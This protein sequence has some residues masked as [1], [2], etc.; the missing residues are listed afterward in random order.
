MWYRWKEKRALALLLLVCLALCLLIAALRGLL[1]VTQG[2]PAKESE[3]LLVYLHEEDRVVSMDLDTYLYGVVGGEMPASFPLEALKAQAVAARTYAVRRMAAYGG[4]PCGRGGADVCTDSTCCQSYKSPETLAER[5]GADAARNADKLKEAVAETHGIIAVYNGEPIEALYHSTT[6]G[7]TEDAQNVFSASLPYLV[8]VDSPGEQDAAHY[9][10]KE[11]MSRS[12]FAKTV[13]KS[14][15]KAKLKAS[16]LEKQV[17]ILS[18]FESGQVETLRLG[19]VELTG[20]EFRKLLD[21]KSAN[22]AFAFTEDDVCI[23]THGYGHGVGMSQYGARA[24]A[25]E[26]ED[27]ESILKH[28]YT[29]IELKQMDVLK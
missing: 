3:C 2:N 18:R 5:W 29:G 28:Y 22:F 21:L 6:G 15:P 25:L 9:T 24:M 8:G 14:W 4:K 26:G 11:T 20:K 27:Y 16:K 1:M 10:D 17:K 7:R 23:T 12:G 13:N 19:N